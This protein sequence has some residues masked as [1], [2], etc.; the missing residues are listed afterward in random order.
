MINSA[1]KISVIIPV[2][3]C[4]RYV[5][6]AIHSVL[7]Q[8]YDNIRIIL[9]DDGSVDASPKICDDYA[10]SYS[11]IRTIHQE[12]SGVSRARNAGIDYVLEH[13]A[14]T[15]YIAFLDADDKWSAGFLDAETVKIIG[16]Q[17]D[18]IGFQACNCN[19][20]ITRRNQPGLL[21]SGIFPGGADNVWLH[22]SQHFA[23]MLYSA[24]L[25]RDYHIR[26]VCNLKYSEDV[27]FRMQCCYLAESMVLHNR[28]L[29]LYRHSVT[30]AVHSRKYGVT[31]FTPIIDGWLNSDKAMEAYQNEKRA[32][33]WEGRAMAAVCIA[34]M[35]EEHYQHFGSKK[36]LNQ[37][38]S[39]HPEWLDLITSPFVSSRP[40][41]GLRWKNMVEHP[42]LFPLQCYIQG[43]TLSAM[44]TVYYFL[45]RIPL[46]A[47][48]L[49]KKR[50]PVAI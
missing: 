36:E 6:E 11:C 30:S 33:L 17:I 24:R 2:Y 9:V 38:L 50:Y 27:I 42:V 29:Y 26:F 37:V 48:W 39:D 49:D 12:N 10:A 41:S 25:I 19:S 8:P 23:S 3:N 4:A 21:Q 22:S 34:D 46:I 44:R 14:D 43:I 32:S 5:E 31:Y 28:L 40:N 13:L 20:A 47:D 15:D 16:G 1:P 7:S 35:A 18:L 45:M